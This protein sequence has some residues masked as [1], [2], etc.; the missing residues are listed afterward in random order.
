MEELIRIREGLMTAVEAQDWMLVKFHVNNIDTLI[1]QLSQLPSSGFA[2]DITLEI[3]LN[4]KIL[5]NHR[6]N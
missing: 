5:W 2:K 3:L 4:E 1:Y 6:K